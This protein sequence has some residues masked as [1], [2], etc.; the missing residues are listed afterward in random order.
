MH[1]TGAA[2]YT[3]VAQEKKLKNRNIVTVVHNVEAPFIRNFLFK[4]IIIHVVSRGRNLNRCN[5]TRQGQPTDQNCFS[6]PLLGTLHVLGPTLLQTTLKEGYTHTLLP[7]IAFSFQC[8]IAYGK[9]TIL[10]LFFRII[11]DN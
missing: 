2:K 11:I 8:S 1:R 5:S 10:Y 9:F 7:S 4:K 6:V 3:V